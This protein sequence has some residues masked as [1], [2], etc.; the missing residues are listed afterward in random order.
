MGLKFYK[1]LHKGKSAVIIAGG[2]SLKKT[3]LDAFDK[4]V[5]RL[6]V[7]LVY[8]GVDDIDYQFIGDRNIFSGNKKILLRETATDPEEKR[9]EKYICPVFTKSSSVFRWLHA[10]FAQDYAMM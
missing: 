4:G 3:N 2:P 1:N 8:R 9:G 7:S 6:G 10:C 5:Y